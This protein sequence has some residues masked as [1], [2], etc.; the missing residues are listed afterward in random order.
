MALPVPK[1]LSMQGSPPELHSCTS[2]AVVGNPLPQAAPLSLPALSPGVLSYLQHRG[3]GCLCH[4]T[5]P[6][7]PEMQLRARAALS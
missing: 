3:P 4:P 6:G 1:G 2:T 5:Q 7:S